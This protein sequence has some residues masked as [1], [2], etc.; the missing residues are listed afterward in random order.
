MRIISLRNLGVQSPDPGLLPPG[1]HLSGAAERCGTRPGTTVPRTGHSE[2]SL[3]PR[4]SPTSRCRLPAAFCALPLKEPPSAVCAGLPPRQR[5]R[6]PRSA[7]VPQSKPAAEPS[8]FT[9]RKHP[10][11]ASRCLRG[12]LGSGGL[13]PPPPPPAA[14]PR[15]P[16]RFKVTSAQGCTE[17]RRSPKTLLPQP[18]RAPAPTCASE[19]SRAEPIRRERGG[20]RCPLSGGARGVGPRTAPPSCAGP[21]R[22]G[23]RWRRISVRLSGAAASGKAL[24]GAVGAGQRLSPPRRG[25]CPSGASPP[26]AGL[27][28][29]SAGRDRRR[30]QLRRGSEQRAATRSGAGD[31]S[32][33]LGPRLSPWAPR[34]RVGLRQGLENR[35]R[36]SEA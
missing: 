32:P 28:L 3:P 15:R 31:A 16:L 18:R 17:G 27:G 25:A 14:F 7:A 8:P 24:G 22:Y 30:V 10:S 33:C 20:G 23:G 4:T 21:L 2:I 36:E 1:S 9:V 19:Q 5:S 34:R 6:R 29:P 35:R 12:G 13:S 26:P 11:A